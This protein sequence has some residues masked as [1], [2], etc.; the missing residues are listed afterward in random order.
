MEAA[1]E[2]CYKLFR[3][4]EP[5]ML[6]HPEDRVHDFLENNVFLFIVMSLMK[7]E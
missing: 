3:A 2:E 1:N 5:E 6:A 7:I 4:K